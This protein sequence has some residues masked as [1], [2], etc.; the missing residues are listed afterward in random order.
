MTP[1]AVCLDGVVLMTAALLVPRLRRFAAWAT[2]G[3]LSFLIAWAA[4]LVAAAAHDSLWLVLLAGASIAASL[5]AS[6]ASMPPLGEDGGGG[7]GGT[8][9]AETHRR[10]PGGRDPEGPRVDWERF[11]REFAAYVRSART[12]GA[13]RPDG[14][15]V[16][17]AS[18]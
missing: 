17:A 16:P 12:A 10:P 1:L 3:T 4:L 18:R 9:R 14:S 15:Q 11:D 13:P 7:D 2:V 6:A 5:G 8:G